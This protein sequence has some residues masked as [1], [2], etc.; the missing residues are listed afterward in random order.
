MTQNVWASIWFVNDDFQKIISLEHCNQSSYLTLIYARQSLT[1]H[2]KKFQTIQLVRCVDIT[3]ITHFFI[4][5]KI[6]AKAI[7]DWHLYQYITN[8][9]C[10]VFSVELKI[11]LSENKLITKIWYSFS[12]FFKSMQL[13]NINTECLVVWPMCH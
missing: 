3:Q 2:Q 4:F 7:I 12:R 9:Y 11:A 13:L 6:T 8:C 1:R 10:T 5:R